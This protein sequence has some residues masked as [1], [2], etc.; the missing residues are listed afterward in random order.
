MNIVSYILNYTSVHDADASSFAFVIVHE[1]AEKRALVFVYMF[2]SRR[3]TE[4][5]RKI[6]ENIEFS[7][8]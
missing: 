4:N 2:F 6:I 3:L 8:L 5:N 7:H 1:D